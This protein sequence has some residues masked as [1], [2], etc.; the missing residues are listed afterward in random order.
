MKEGK[1]PCQYPESIMPYKFGQFDDDKCI[2]K[3]VAEILRQEGQ[4]SRT[5]MVRMGSRYP[6]QE[7]QR[8]RKQG[9]DIKTYRQGRSAS[10]YC[11]NSYG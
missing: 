10:V 9:M 8:L 11:L 6:S 1:I 4:I 7:I 2:M 3:R 5:E